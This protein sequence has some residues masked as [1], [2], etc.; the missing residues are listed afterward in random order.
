MTELE[1]EA[2]CIFQAATGRTCPNGVASRYASALQSKGQV[3]NTSVPKWLLDRPN[4]FRWCEP[5]AGQCPEMDRRRRMIVQLAESHPET[6]PLF[7][8]LGEVS[9]LVESLSLIRI[10]CVE[11]LRL[12]FRFILSIALWR[13]PNI[14]LL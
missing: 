8:N 14:K 5:I 4:L 9:S 3:V 7:Y 11:C 1:K 2:N 13:S 12:L 10:L 6:A